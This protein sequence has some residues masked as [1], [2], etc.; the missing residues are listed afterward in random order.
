[1]EHMF[2]EYGYNIDNKYVLI[3]CTLETR[4]KAIQMCKEQLDKGFHV[5]SNM[6]ISH[7]PRFIHIKEK[8]NKPYYIYRVY[9]I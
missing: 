7:H 8:T 3:I 5:L 2:E 4:D 1:M 9:S 6:L